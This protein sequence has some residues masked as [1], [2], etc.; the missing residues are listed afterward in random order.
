MDFPPQDLQITDGKFSQQPTINDG[1]NPSQSFSKTAA[2]ASRRQ[3]QAP[4][5]AKSNHDKERIESDIR[6]VENPGVELDEQDGVREEGNLKEE[7]VAPRLDRLPSV[8]TAM[9]STPFSQG[10]RRR[11]SASPE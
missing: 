4:P 7:S 1:F 5:I 3:S 2:E 10:D 6:S 8:R 9:Q 11:N